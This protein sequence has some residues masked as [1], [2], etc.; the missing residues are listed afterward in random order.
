MNKVVIDYG[1]G[2]AD[3]YC[4]ASD[5]KQVER[6]FYA[7][8]NHCF[9]IRKSIM[10]Y[11]VRGTYPNV[12][13]PLPYRGHGATH[14]LSHHGDEIL[15]DANHHQDEHGLEYW[16]LHDES[17]DWCSCRERGKAQLDCTVHHFWVPDHDEACA[18]CKAR[19]AAR[20]AEVTA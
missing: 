17:G 11:E 12:D 4:E 8:A 5:P 16:K 13:L 20:K 14:F 2:A 10:R 3:F 7:C 15:F 18:E 6:E 19:D 9:G 1:D